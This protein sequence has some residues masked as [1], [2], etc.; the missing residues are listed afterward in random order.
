MIAQENQLGIDV[1]YIL[2]NGTKTYRQEAISQLK[3]ALENISSS[4]SLDYEE[5]KNK[6]LSPHIG[7]NIIIVRLDSFKTD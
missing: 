3:T 6:I 1:R 2:K 5:L 4:L 7:D